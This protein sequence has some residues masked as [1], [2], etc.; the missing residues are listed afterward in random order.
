MRCAVAFLSLIGLFFSAFGRTVEQKERAPDFV[1][2]SLGNRTVR[3][4]DYKGKVVLLNFWATWCPP[5]RVETPEL[6]R[7]QKQYEDKGLQI[8]GI[9]YPPYKKATVI[10]FAK[11]SKINYPVVFDNHKI[12]GLYSVGEILPVTIIVDRQ[13][14]IADRILGIL[15]PQ[16]FERKV[17]PLLE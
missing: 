11:N 9:T 15:E 12:A 8:I 14:M 4:S 17:K 13:G 3:L 10:R 5:C 6:V 7:W 1:L 2:K 16:E